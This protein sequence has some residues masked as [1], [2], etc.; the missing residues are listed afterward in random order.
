MLVQGLIN[1]YLVVQI[2]CP[3][4]QLDLDG[5]LDFI[6]HLVVVSAWTLAIHGGFSQELDT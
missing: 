1:P 6:L 4:F 3:I 2:V 5:T